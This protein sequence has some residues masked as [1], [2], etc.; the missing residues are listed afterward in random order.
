MEFD[1][2]IKDMIMTSMNSNITTF[3][4]N[5]YYITLMGEI[6]AVSRLFP[7]KLIFQRWRLASL[8]NFQSK[9]I[10][11]RQRLTIPLILLHSIP[12]TRRFETLKIPDIQY[13]YIFF[14]RFNYIQYS[15]FFSAFF[16]FDTNRKGVKRQI[17]IT[18]KNSYFI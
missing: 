16:S 17:Y 3:Q 1:W 14:D 2:Q 8:P 10:S 6:F 12:Q 11:R 18:L 7:S 5:I 4:E 13:L 15:S 9:S